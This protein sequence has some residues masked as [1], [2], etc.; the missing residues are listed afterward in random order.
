MSM[1]RAT[2]SHIQATYW[3]QRA[4]SHHTETQIAAKEATA[5]KHQVRDPHHTEAQIAAKEAAND[6]WSGE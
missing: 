4:F 5:K 2:M 3:R 6:A 1:I